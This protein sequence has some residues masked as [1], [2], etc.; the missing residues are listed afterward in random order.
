MNKE[1][2]VTEMQQGFIL[3]VAPVIHAL[4]EQLGVVATRAGIEEGRL[5]NF[6]AGEHGLSDIDFTRIASTMNT[7]Y[8]YLQWEGGHSAHAFSFRENYTLFPNTEKQIINLYDCVTRGGDFDLACELV[9]SS[10]YVNHGIRY[11][12]VD[13]NYH[14]TL[15]CVADSELLDDLI[16][17]DR[18]YHFDGVRLVSD[19]LN[20]AV[21]EHVERISAEPE[22]RSVFDKDFF[23]GK[24]L[25]F[26]QLALSKEIADQ[27]TMERFPV[28]K[29]SR[30]GS[31]RK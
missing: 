4:P 27:D 10:N 20:L 11:I 8:Q 26:S 21:M 17:Q 7:E 19:D 6:L 25:V 13:R 31:G 24:E 29:R 12:F 2:T 14:Y 18:L 5:R 23:A 28:G 3:D 22:D 9:A 1:P 16:E 30:Q 15:I